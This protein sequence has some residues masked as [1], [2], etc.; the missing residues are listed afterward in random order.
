[1]AFEDY[2]YTIEDDKGYSPTEWGPLGE[3]LD[4]LEKYDDYKM[5]TYAIVRRPLPVRFVVASA[6]WGGHV[7]VH[8]VAKDREV[9]EDILEYLRDYR[10]C[11]EPLGI[12]ETYN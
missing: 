5:S 6:G 10:S 11:D 4:A 9:A 3:A 12:D 2:E 7:E 8:G 1:M